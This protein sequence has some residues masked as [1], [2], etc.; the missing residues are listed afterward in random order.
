ML[1]DYDGASAAETSSSDRQLKGS[2]P[3]SPLQAESVGAPAPVLV[4]TPEEAS[5]VH[6]LEVHL[7]LGVAHLLRPGQV[8]T[9]LLHLARSEASSQ[10]GGRSSGA[11]A[12]LHDDESGDDGPVEGRS[13]GG[14]R[15]APQ[16]SEELLPLLLSRLGARM[17]SRLAAYDER[18]LV[19]VC[20][21]MSR[22]R[23]R[24]G[25]L[26]QVTFCV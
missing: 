3:A 4:F 25:L 2:D 9:L 1:P 23:W 26:L 14:G 15:L 12:A 24:P 6:H 21:A 20:T 22:L 8:V 17:T 7:A 10:W 16:P 11:A 13:A 18:Q 19:A 5:C